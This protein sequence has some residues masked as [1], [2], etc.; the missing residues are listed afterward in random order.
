MPDMSAGSNSGE[1]RAEPRIGYGHAC[2]CCQ[3]LLK[4]CERCVDDRQRAEIKTGPEGP[5]SY[6]LAERVGQL[7]RSIKSHTKQSLSTVDKISVYHRLCTSQACN[8]L[9]SD[10]L[11]LAPR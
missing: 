4:Y 10:M 9:Q 7:P 1:C 11:T 8:A 2:A 3:R 5:V 6:V